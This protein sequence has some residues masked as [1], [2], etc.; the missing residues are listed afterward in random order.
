MTKNEA[1]T[2]MDAQRAAVA[3]SAPTPVEAKTLVEAKTPAETSKT[4]K[5]QPILPSH[6]NPDLLKILAPVKNQYGIGYDAPIEYDGGQLLVQFGTENEPFYTQNGMEAWSSANNKFVSI[7]G[8]NN[9]WVNWFNYRTKMTQ[10]VQ[11]KLRLQDY[12]RIGSQGFFSYEF[13]KKLR[14]MIVDCLVNG[15]NEC[16]EKGN[17]IPLS[18]MPKRNVDVMDVLLTTPY[19]P[20]SGEYDPKLN[21]KVRFKVK[22]YADD[23]DA[24]DV[25]VNGSALHYDS[26]ALKN[27]V[28]TYETYVE[29]MPDESKKETMTFT[30]NDA[31]AEQLLRKGSSGIWVVRFDSVLINSKGTFSLTCELVKASL[32]LPTPYKSTIQFADEAMP[33]SGFAAAAAAAAAA[34]TGTGENAAHAPPSNDGEPPMKRQN[35]SA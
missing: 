19:E 9:D 29:E 21:I 25:K 10:K 16:D 15:S 2:I 17:R 5:R 7:D 18:N 1:G 31:G 28:V 13:L 11:L 30:R 12:N 20:P 14:E 24:L 34:H 35:T 6:F 32:R 8:S 3:E 23:K 4:Y 33:I 26:E 22:K 27:V